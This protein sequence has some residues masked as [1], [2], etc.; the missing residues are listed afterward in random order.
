M[1][2]LLALPIDGPYESSSRC[3]NGWPVLD[4][5]FKHSEYIASSDAGV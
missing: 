2:L 1:L 5:A 4:L 3:T